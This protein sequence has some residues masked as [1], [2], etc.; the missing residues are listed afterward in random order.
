M[1]RKITK[2]YSNGEVTIVWKNSLCWHSGH[3]VRE[4]PEVFDRSKHPWIKPDGAGTEEIVEQ[5]KRCPSRALSYF[6]NNEGQR[7]NFDEQNS[8]S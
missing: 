2:E 1:N 3:C 5:V 7:T 6:M 8:D 4:L